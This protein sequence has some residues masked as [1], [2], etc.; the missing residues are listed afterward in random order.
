MKNN[1]QDNH[2]R[3][4]P[5]AYYK[6][7]DRFKNYSIEKLLYEYNRGHIDNS[8]TAT[9]RW[10]HLSAI[11]DLLNDKGVG[12][13]EYLNYMLYYS[14]II[15]HRIVRSDQLNAKDIIKRLEEFLS[16]FYPE[17]YKTGYQLLSWKDNQ[18]IVIKTHRT[19]ETLS[20]KSNEV[21][22]YYDKTNCCFNDDLFSKN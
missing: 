3:K 1:K 12:N 5:E 14:F 19:A 6:Y 7:L 11:R 10:L 18:H 21:F 22:K 9:I 20:L 4:Y 13:L 15:D 16:A 2:H 8:G 17:I